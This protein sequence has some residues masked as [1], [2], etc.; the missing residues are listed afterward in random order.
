MPRFLTDMLFRLR[1]LFDRG[2]TDRELQD[3]L[4]FHLSMDAAKLRSEGYSAAAAER[5]ARVRFGTVTGA[6]EEARGGWGISMLEEL[7]VDARRASRQMRRNPGFTGIVL[8]A[9]GLGIGASVALLSVVNSLVLRPLPYLNESRAHVFW[10]DY[11]W[12]FQEYD[13]LRE[14]LSVF[15]AMAVFSTDGASYSI[16]HNPGQAASVLSYVVS[17]PSLFEVLGARPLLGRVYDANDDRPGAP[18]VVV[19]SYGTWQQDFAGDPS[20][21]GRQVEL[22]ETPTTIIG[23]MPREFFFPTPDQRAWRPL[24]INSSEKRFQDR[25]LVVVARTRADVEL[26]AGPSLRS[27]RRETVARE[28]Q[29][30]AKELGARFTYPPAWDHTRNASA[31][32]MREYVLGKVR[33]PLLLLLGAV[34]LLLLIACANAAA[35]ILVRTTDRSTEMSV[36]KALGAGAGRLAR[37]VFAESLV[38]ALCAAVVGSAVAAAGFR[39]LVARLPLNSGLD[40]VTSMGATAFVAAFGLALFIALVVSIIPM[41]NLL[42]GRVGNVG[43]E[44]SDPRL[45]RG[46]RRVHGG[47]IGFQ[48]AFALLL[49]VGATLLIRSVER[50]RDIDLGIDPRGVMTA[51]IFAASGISPAARAEMFRQLTERVAALPGVT[52][53]GLTNRLPVR[54]RGYSTSITIEGHPAPADRKPSALYRL[55][56]PGLFRAIDM[57]VVEGRAFDS[58]DVAGGTPVVIINETFARAMWPGESAIGKHVGDLWTGTEVQRTVIGVVH[59]VKLPGPTAK[60][61]LA[62]WAPFSQA[63][64]NQTAAVMLVKSAGPPG[65]LA[66]TLRRVIGETD[67]R[68]AIARMQSLQD[69]VDGTLATPLQLRFFFTLFAALAVALGSIGVFGLVSYAVARRRAEFAVRMALGASPDIVGREMLAFGITPVVIGTLT[70]SV[71]A[72]GAARFITGVLYGIAPADPSSFTASAAT[73][74]LAGAFAA[75]VPALRAGRTSPAEA[76]RSDS[77]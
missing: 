18:A 32:S 70:G 31:I 58:T 40:T 12:N 28:M 16:G 2:T 54:D 17:T 66:Q 39:L 24:Q 45:H 72:L 43:R 49:V 6:A 33:E 57:R 3:E 69:A 1:A 56:T 4:S 52:S 26:K 44:R 29:R 10:A 55:A 51:N 63:G 50:L 22:D 64:P 42:L 19:L 8:G 48:V 73:L 20:V 77:T 34:G 36:R 67:S 11:S 37:Q 25:Y 71:A 60:P 53:V 13:F 9:L 62:I 41:R 23:V 21:I 5:E 38:L 75:L 59:D 14:R 27:G 35:L 61:S 76:L 74:L 15:D 65:N 7:L 30:L 47:I 46:A 68:F